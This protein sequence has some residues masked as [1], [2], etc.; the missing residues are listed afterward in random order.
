[1]I[2]AKSVYEYSQF[3][4]LLYVED[5][6]DLRNETCSLFEPLFSHVDT[7]QNGQ[8]GLDKYNQNEYDIV[9]TDINMPIMSGIEM[10]NNIREI[11]PEQKIIT[12]SAHNEPD[13][14]INLIRS[15]SSSFI[16]KPAIH[17]EMLATL[18]TVC[19][20]A[21]AQQVNL[22]SYQ[23]INDQR[24][25]LEKQIRLLKSQ[26]NTIEV[27]NQQVEKLICKQEPDESED[28]V[29]TDYFQR[30]E[31]EGYENVVFNHDDCDEITELMNDISNEFALYSMDIDT[32]H[33]DNISNHFRKVSSVF[34]LYM[35]FLD[36]LAQSMDDLGRVL[37]DSKEAFI[38]L[39]KENQ[40]LT[41]ALFDAISVDIEKYVERF[42]KES[43]AVRNI[44][45]IH[46]PTMLSIQQVIGLINPEDVEEGEIDFF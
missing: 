11:N 20:D 37:M 26:N 35:P 27:K 28:T 24:E 34:S 21:R 9:I 46:Q 36:P 44:H 29:L 22:E 25:E 42:S 30:D 23:I 1:M 12:V 7:A 17:E 45:H 8:E 5:D 41:L 40:E 2:T 6:E 3:L 43:M 39:Y 33:I 15:G 4:R 19:R 38:N 10:I 13:I 18:Y 32:E 14:L 16:L 31:D